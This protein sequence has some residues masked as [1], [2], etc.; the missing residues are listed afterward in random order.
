MAW[1]KHRVVPHG[2]QTLCDAVDQVFVVTTRKICAANAACKQH[3]TYKRT[4][5]FGR[6]KHHMAG[7][8][9]WAV[10]HL[11]R[12]RAKCDRVAIVQPARGLESA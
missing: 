7:C 2:P 12:V 3:I 9:A 5:D 6:I 4:F 1:N 10:A 11:Q 8:V